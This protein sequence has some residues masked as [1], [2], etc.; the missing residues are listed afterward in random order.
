MRT[1]AELVARRGEP[2]HRL[3]DPAMHIWHYPLGIAGGTLYSVHVAGV[4]DDTPMTYMHVKPTS[5]ADT[6]AG[7]VVAVLVGAAPLRHTEA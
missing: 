6:M 2:A 3:D 4:R 1:P 5:E 7:S